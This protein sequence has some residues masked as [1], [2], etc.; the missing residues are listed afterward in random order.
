MGRNAAKVETIGCAM[1]PC[2]HSEQRGGWGCYLCDIIAKLGN[3]PLRPT[4]RKAKV[5]KLF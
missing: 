3:K 5:K 1:G 4:P 2:I